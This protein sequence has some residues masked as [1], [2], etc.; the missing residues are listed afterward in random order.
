MSA[1]EP[2]P[3]QRVDPDHLPDVRAQQQHRQ[4]VAE[5]EGAAEPFVQR[6]PHHPRLLEFLHA[7]T[8]RFEQPLVQRDPGQA[9]IDQ[10]PP[11]LASHRRFTVQPA[12]EQLGDG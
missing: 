5:Q 3:G 10:E 8:R 1:G 2:V 6:W 11:D 12:G 4:I 7:R 9:A